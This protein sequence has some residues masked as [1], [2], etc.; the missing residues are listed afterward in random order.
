MSLLL[1]C[2]AI[3]PAFAAESPDAM[4]KRIRDMEKAN[5]VLQEDLA[6]TQLELDNTLTKLK[7][8]IVARK[9]MEAQLA[10]EVAFRTKQT[11]DLAKQSAELTSAMNAKLT[12]LK[13]VLAK[14][15]EQIAAVTTA[16]DSEKNT[17]I[18]AETDAAK[19]RAKMAKDNKRSHIIGYALSGLLGAVA[20]SR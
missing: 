18:A 14:Q 11:E 2:S 4:G 16:L 7:T 19:L 10:E 12:D 13:D 8:E 20:I 5:L 17:R 6:R 3:I 15:A 9:T 1:L